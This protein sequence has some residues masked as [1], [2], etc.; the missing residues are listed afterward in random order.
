MSAHALVLRNY[1]H[2]SYRQWY[3]ETTLISVIHNADHTFSTIPR[4]LPPKL[5]HLNNLQLVKLE[6]LRLKIK[7]QSKA[8]DCRY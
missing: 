7:V 4:F 5:N 3:Q 8:L 2:F 1:T 6:M